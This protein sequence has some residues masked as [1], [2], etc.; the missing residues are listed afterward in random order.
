MSCQKPSF[1]H[2]EPHLHP[3][4]SLLPLEP[5]FEMNQIFKAGWGGVVIIFLPSRKKKKKTQLSDPLAF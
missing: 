5:S 2:D 1:P 4:T 3:Y